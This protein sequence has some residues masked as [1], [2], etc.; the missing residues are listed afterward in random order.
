MST[1]QNYITALWLIAYIPKMAYLYVRENWRMLATVAACLIALFAVSYHLGKDGTAATAASASATYDGGGFG[2]V[3]LTAAFATGEKRSMQVELVAIHHTAGRAD[4]TVNDI[5]RVHFGEH[6][7]SG[8]GYHFF[9]EQDGTTYQLR[10]LNERVP[11]AYGCNDNAIAICLAG[12]FSQYEV[13]PAQWTAA[14]QL[15]RWLMRKYSLGKSNVLTHSECKV[16]SPLN[17]TE[18][19]GTK[20]NANKFREEL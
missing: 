9:I 19:C 15:T 14:L 6:K 5:C 16:Y 13:P 18:C 12:N 7:W 11:H 2:F 10:P 8:V 17:N 3:D 4:G 20:F 1:I